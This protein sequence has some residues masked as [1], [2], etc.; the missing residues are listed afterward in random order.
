MRLAAAWLTCLLALPALAAEKPRVCLIE[1]SDSTNQVP[2]GPSIALLETELRRAFLV[3]P[4]KRVAKAAKQEKLPRNRWLEA[5]SLAKLSKRLSFD[6]ALGARA[7]STFGTWTLYLTAWDA[8]TG[9]V[10][11]E[12]SVILSRPRIPESR[13]RDLVFNLLEA[14]GTAREPEKPAEPPVDTPPPPPPDSGTT[15][16]TGGGDVWDMATEG[17]SAATT[18]ATSSESLRSETSVEV[19]GRV[20]FEHYAFFTNAG[21]DKLSSRD[22]VDAAV[23]V[24]AVHPRAT[25]YASV[26]ARYDFADTSRNR[27]EP[28]E[29]W[30]ELNFPGVSL[31]AGRFVSSWGT[32]SL[33]NPSDVLNPVDLR[34]PLD[35]EKWGTMMVKASATVGPA[36]LEAYYLPV[37]EMHRVPVITG[38]APD[39]RLES[40]SRWIR[41]SIDV[42]V[43]APVTFAVSPMQPP[44]PRP[45][46]TQ[47]A[48]RAL[49][50]VGGADLSVGYA[51]LV[52]RFP[53]P[54][55]EAVPDPGVP[56]NTT[57]HLDWV[58]RRLHVITL[59]AERTFG[60]LRLAGEAAAFLTRDL[61][62]VNR[63]V[64][65]PFVL[66]DV[67]ADY[68]TS[69]FLDD[70]RLHF[71]L[72]FVTAQPLVGKV[73]TEGMDL[74]R[75]PFPLSLVGRVSW[76][77][78]TDLK[79]DVNAVSSLKRFDVM[80]SPRLEY[81][82]FDRVKAQVGVDLLLGD[83]DEGFFGPYRDNSRFI[84]TV[85]SRF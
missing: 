33:Y 7:A 22:N 3:V 58:Y 19:G 44:P 37:P 32:A 69:A 13:A 2:V 66:V 64:T 81:A 84:A 71:F 35:P 10:R 76:E 23:R 56:L 29:A 8:K 40:R 79:V 16:G 72:E 41:G 45:S 47:V 31:K 4:N 82:F 55:V 20:G 78:G 42:D 57:V 30:V 77:I 73:A 9:E 74:W 67:G 14:L 53:S 75:Y 34:D 83:P 38:I 49:L 6:L 46:N 63:N 18:E 5:P 27:F 68:Q 50:S 39:G 12:T 62:G 52:D 28:E 85:E 80:L 1:L 24:K 48:A 17:F 21:P 61:E 65:D 43:S 54:L 36:T 15:T 25:A 11:A 26:L 60:K 59:D 70:Q 51:Y